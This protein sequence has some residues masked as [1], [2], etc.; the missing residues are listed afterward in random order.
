MRDFYV[1][2]AGGH[3]A[4]VAEIISELGY[5]IAGFVDD[6]PA[7]IGSKVL[8]WEVIGGCECVPERAAVALGI[9]D[10]RARGE[11]LTKIR[12]RGWFLPVLIHPSA[13]VSQSAVL[14]AGT[15]VMAQVVVNARASV[16][17][18][19]ILNTACSVDHDCSLGDAV[20]ICP[21]T[22]L[23]GGVTVGTGTMIGIGSC[24]R[25]C[26]RIGSHCTLGAG[27]VVVTDICDEITVFGNP[28]RD[29]ANDYRAT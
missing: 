26:A 11:L 19:C 14:G 5:R 27:S 4:V 20:H 18:G 22:R 13:I 28:A 23:A 9:G 25:P 24:V 8:D 16:G 15:V 12:D 21:G 10:N 7:L 3:G 29:R 6:D 2:G 17:C 1:I